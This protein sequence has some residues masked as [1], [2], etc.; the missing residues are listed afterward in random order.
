MK[1]GMG[2]NT[3]DGITKLIVLYKL[4]NKYT[5]Y[6]LSHNNYKCHMHSKLFNKYKE[7]IIFDIK[8]NDSIKIDKNN[9]IIYKK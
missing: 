9:N 2:I 5:F 3:K 8:N 1:F 7:Y 4:I 6:D